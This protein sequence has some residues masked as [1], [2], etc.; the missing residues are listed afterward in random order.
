[1]EED[2]LW[3][4]SQETMFWNDVDDSVDIPLPLKSINEEVP[5]VVAYIEPKDV[6]DKLKCNRWP[7]GISQLDL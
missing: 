7:K 4:D 3:T 1:M 6:S 5:T 2:T